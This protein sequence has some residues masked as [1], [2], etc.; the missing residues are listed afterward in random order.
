MLQS[1]NLHA[2]Y[3]GKFMT[4]RRG[5]LGERCP[6]EFET[7]FEDRTNLSSGFVPLVSIDYHRASFGPGSG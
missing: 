1:N 5:L 3:P 4:F 7:I 2:L 6:I